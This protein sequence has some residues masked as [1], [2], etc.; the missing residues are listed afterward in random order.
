MSGVRGRMKEYPMRRDQLLSW[1]FSPVKCRFRGRD[2]RDQVGAPLW[3]ETRTQFD[4]DFIQDAGST[5]A[6]EFSWQTFPVPHL[7]NSICCLVYEKHQGK[8]YQFYT[9]PKAWSTAKTHQF[10]KSSTIFF[11]PRI[12]ANSQV[13][14]LFFFFF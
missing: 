1:K 11:P 7:E 8:F 4:S 5:R 6:A 14:G 9:I 10:S 2:I 3:L 13:H 12:R